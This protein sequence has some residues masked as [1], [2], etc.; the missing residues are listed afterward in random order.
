MSLL[1]GDDFVGKTDLAGDDYAFYN[2]KSL[3]KIEIPDGVTSIGFWS[4]ACCSSLTSVTIPG[5]VGYIRD[6]MFYD[7]IKLTDVIVCDGVTSI[8]NRAFGNVHTAFTLPS[9]LRTI[10]SEAFADGGAGALV[11]PN[12]VE[13][14][15]GYCFGSSYFTSITIPSSVTSIGLQLMSYC[16]SLTTITCNAN[17]QEL[18]ISFAEYCQSLT[19][20]TLPSTLTAF[21]MDGC[22]FIACD[23]LP[24]ITIPASVTDIAANQVFAKCDAL[25]EIHFL[26]NMPNTY[27]SYVGEQ[28][29]PFGN[30]SAWMD[31][32]DEEQR[33]CGAQYDEQTGQW[34]VSGTLYVP[35]SDSTWD[36][37]ASD[38]AFATL[39]DNGWSLV[40]E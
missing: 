22:Q 13:T 2:C 37:V 40:R 28:K 25:R 35:T 29:M 5:D 1:Y 16:G 10:D 7:C 26:G 9:S 21:H 8:G 20:V 24:S 12:G 4:F 33:P 34:T 31:D 19:S 14:I 36:N 3:T 17:I 6:G 30:Y 38:P 39:L 15:G 11:I 27:S 23:S 18:P 32:G